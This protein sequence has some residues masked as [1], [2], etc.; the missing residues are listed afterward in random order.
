MTVDE[1]RALERIRRRAYAGRVVFSGH[2]K[3]RIAQRGAS[4][5]DVRHVLC[6]AGTCKAGENERWLVTGPDLSGD[7]LT[8]VVVIE[9]LVVVVT[10]F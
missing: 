1:V 5:S 6:T 7:E 4:P 9:D 2:A 10:V 3:M 8:V